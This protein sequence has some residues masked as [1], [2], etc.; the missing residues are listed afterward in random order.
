[1]DK[2]TTLRSRHPGSYRDYN[3]KRD[4]E[5]EVATDTTGYWFAAAV[6]FAFLA[7]GIMVYRTG[8]PDIRT[9]SNDTAVAA[10]ASPVDLPPLHAH[11]E[12]VDP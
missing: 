2:P 5:F 6:I 11:V 3:R 7:A 8:N 12:G 10:R 9:A 1:M 4:L